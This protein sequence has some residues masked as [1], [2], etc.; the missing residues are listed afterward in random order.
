MIRTNVTL[1]ADRN[2][3]L[4]IEAYKCYRDLIKIEVFNFLYIRTSRQIVGRERLSISSTAC[5]E[6]VT[7]N[8]I[9]DHPLT[10]DV[11]GLRITKDIDE[12][13]MHLPIFGKTIYARSVYSIEKN[14][15]AIIDDSTLISPLGNLDNCTLSTGTCL[16]DGAVVVWKPTI[17]LPS[18]RMQVVDTFEALVT[19][20]YVLIPAHELAFEFD[21]DQLKTYN[22]LK[23]CTIEQVPNMI[24]TVVLTP[25]LP[26]NDRND[27]KR[28]VED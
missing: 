26:F 6:A 28:A 9:F 23:S 7:S 4:E 15:I 21:T 11:P 17:S 10:E 25:S 14:T 20:R 19:L 24:C 8:V 18:C 27:V 3:L 22:A 16:T 1:Y 13:N 5:K 2:D 12:E